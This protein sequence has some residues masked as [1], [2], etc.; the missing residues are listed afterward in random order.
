MTVTVAVAGE[1]GGWPLDAPALSL[2]LD[3]LVDNAIAASRPG[4]AVRLLAHRL[5][6]EGE[7][8]EIRVEDDGAGMTPEAIAQASRIGFSS[9]GRPGLGLA[10]ARQAVKGLRGSLLLSSEGPE[11]GTTVRIELPLDE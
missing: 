1:A 3:A 5:G 11:R 9:R 8:G 10:V 4:G 6:D 7:R 2:A